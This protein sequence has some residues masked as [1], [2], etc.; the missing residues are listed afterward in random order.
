MKQLFLCALLV[1]MLAGTGACTSKPTTDQ[2]S[3]T[4]EN[5]SSNG[6]GGGM[7]GGY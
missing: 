7:G 3:Q 2:H 1:L 5:G 4:Q 6:M